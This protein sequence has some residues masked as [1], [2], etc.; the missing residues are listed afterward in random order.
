LI[1]DKM[2]V[3]LKKKFVVAIAASTLC[4]FGL[5][6]YI[7]TFPINSNFHGVVKGK[8]YRSGQPRIE[9]LRSW[10]NRYGIKTII[11]LRGAK[12]PHAAEEVQLAKELNVRIVFIE[13]SAYKLITREQFNELLDV[14]ETA[15]Q[16]VLIHCKSGIDR[17]GTVSTLAAW[18]VG[19][20]DFETAER[21]MYVPP[22][23]WKRRW[24]VSPHISDTL[25]MYED[26]C[27]RNKL[28]LDS[29]EGFDNWRNTVYI[30][31]L[32][33]LKNRN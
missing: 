33:G 22:G 15:Q 17:A 2:R 31:Y 19:G 16:P 29:I 5:S 1:L 23:P 24:F 14:L 7:W 11:N 6:Y 20:K 32:R 8:I 4:A 9:Q 10:I 25:E 26:Y 30:E 3:K 28:D 21:Q 13:L 18:L 27:Y 12:A